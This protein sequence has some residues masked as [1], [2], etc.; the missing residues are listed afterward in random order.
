M[1]KKRVIMTLSSVRIILPISYGYKW[2]VWGIL[3]TSVGIEAREKYLRFASISTLTVS[4][5]LDG[6]IGYFYDCFQT[7]Y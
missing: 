2:K 3:A 6:S 7:S 1:A 5:L 4:K